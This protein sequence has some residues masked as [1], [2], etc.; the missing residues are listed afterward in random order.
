LFPMDLEFDDRIYAKPFS[1]YP[2]LHKI[3]LPT[4]YGQL[5]PMIQFNIDLAQIQV[6]FLIFIRISAILMS[7]PVIGGNNVPMVFKI[8]LALSVSVVFSPILKLEGF[9]YPFETIPFVL[10]ILSEIILGLMIGLSINLV[11]AGIEL[12]GQLTGYQMGFAIANVMDPQSGNQ[13]SILASLLSISALLM[14]LVFNVHH[15]FL[16]SL[17]DI[18]ELV[19]IFSFKVTGSVVDFCMRL[20]GNMFMIAVKVAAP[21]MS[22]LLIASVCLGLIART[23][24][25]MNVFLVGMPLKIGLGLIFTAFSL[26][27]LASYLFYLFNEVGGSLMHLLKN[28]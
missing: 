14:F 4:S 25:K 21:V 5:K 1:E 22:V 17:S 26:P 20:A 13:T 3:G 9:A 7:L 27:Y 19:P 16:R 28:L 18:F 10:G 15:W 8:G 6:F 11:F 23:V 12:A 2:Q 24:P